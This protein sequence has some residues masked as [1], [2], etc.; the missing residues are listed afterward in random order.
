MSW[1]IYSPEARLQSLPE[2]CTPIATQISSDKHLSQYSIIVLN[3]EILQFYQ[4]EYLKQHQSESKEELEENVFTQLLSLDID[5]M[6]VYKDISEQKMFRGM[7]RDGIKAASIYISC[8]LNDCPRTAHEIAE[9]FK[10][11][12][13]SATTGCSMAVN[14]LHNIKLKNQNIDSRAYFYPLSDM[15]MYE[16]ADTPITHKVYQS[17]V[18]LPSYFD[19]TKEQVK[20]V[21]EEIMGTL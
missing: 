15:P 12:K 1:Y 3:K 4:S 14:I 2:F 8:R 5:A 11:D 21:C 19:I 16:N 13:T 7:N 10:L 9:I 18:N 6:I 20:Y 17:G